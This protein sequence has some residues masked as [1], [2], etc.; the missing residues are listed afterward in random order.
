MGEGD[1]LRKRLDASPHW[2]GLTAL[3]P[4]LPAR[5]ARVL[6]TA[7]G[8][9]RDA[10]QRFVPGPPPDV[11]PLEPGFG[12][13]PAEQ[14]LAWGLAQG[15][16]LKTIAAAQNVSINTLRNQLQAIYDKTGVNRQA[17]LVSL[18]LEGRKAGT[19]DPPA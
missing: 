8:P 13:T 7:E 16:S 3:Y 15:G 4:S 6:A 14:R 11:E 2:R 1:D 19:A 12:L 5:F 17:A 18:L 9:L 10:M